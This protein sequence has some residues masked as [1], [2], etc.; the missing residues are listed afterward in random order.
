[1]LP[2]HL[3]PLPCYLLD[4]PLLLN[5]PLLLRLEKILEVP[6]PCLLPE[7]LSFKLGILH[8][9]AFNEALHVFYLC[10]DLVKPLLVLDALLV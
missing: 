7:H 5:Y 2:H 8:L 6:D 3:V 9:F 1:V 10:A 4:C